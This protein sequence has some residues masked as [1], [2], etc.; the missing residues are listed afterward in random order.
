MTDDPLALTQPRLP[1]RCNKAL[2]AC[3]GNGTG[4]STYFARYLYPLTSLVEQITPPQSEDAGLFYGWGG[5]TIPEESAFVS[6]GTTGLQT[7]EASLR[8]GAHLLAHQTSLLP[9]GSRVLELGAGAGFLAS[10]CTQVL[11]SAGGG[12]VVATDVA[13]NVLTRLAEARRINSYTPAE[14]E[15]DAFD[16]FDALPPSSTNLST[17]TDKH[18]EESLGPHIL[19]KILEPPDEGL[20]LLQ[21][22]KPTL[23]LAADVVFDPAILPA[24]VHTLHA[25]LQI[26]IDASGSNTPSP[27]AL[28]AST[29]R[30]EATYTRFLDHLTDAGL[31]YEPVTLSPYPA[32]SLPTRW[33][34]G[35]A[36]NNDTTFEYTCFPSAHVPE[37]D[38]R[39]ELLDIS[40]GPR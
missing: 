33:I 30:N 26:S 8:L 6:E 37:C 7:W 1:A 19:S 32:L 13:P 35:H 14:M 3:E 38:G 39:V 22:L 29:Q 34:E 17:Q 31:A 16:F 10:L 15:V 24:L 20:Q 4:A 5:I 21:A 11:K 40:L 27:R 25:A 23:I 12:R 18:S 2:H 28:V 9:R 36:N